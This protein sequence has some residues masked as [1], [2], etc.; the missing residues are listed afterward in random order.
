MVVRTLLAQ[1]ADPE[2]PGPD[3]DTPMTRAKYACPAEVME[4]LASG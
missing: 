4:V 1:G 2:R 3:G